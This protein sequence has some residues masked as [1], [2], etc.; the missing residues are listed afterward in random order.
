MSA[1]LA[2][3]DDVLRDAVRRHGGH[4]FSTAGDAFAAAFHT[5]TDALDAA[6]TAQRALQAT[7]WPGPVIRVRM[8]IHTGEAEERDGD[9]FGPVLNKVA[10]IM[11]A[12]NGGQILLSASAAELSSTWLSDDTSLIDL[13]AHR[14]HDVPGTEHLF[15]A[16]HVEL[17][18]IDLAIRTTQER[19]HNLPEY[20]TTFVGRESELATIA[21]LL[22]DHRLVT[23]SGV[24]GTGKTRLAV[25]TARRMTKGLSGGRWLVELAPVVDSDNIMLTIG[26][27]LELRPGPG[28]SIDEVVARHLA[29]LETLVIIDNCEHVLEGAID[30]ISTL[31]SAGPGVKVLAT[32]RESLGITGEAIVRVPSLGLP[33]DAGSLA[34]VESVHLFLDRAGEVR[35]GFEPTE[36]DLRAIA[37]ICVRIDGIPLGLEL[38][39]A[40]LRSLA[41]ADLA[42][43]L[44]E[45]FR[46]L[47]GSAKTALPR[48]RTLNATIDW[49]HDLLTPA[50]RAV[51]RRMA[52]FLNGFDLTAAEA[53][54]S[55]DSVDEADVLDRLDSLVD[56]SLLVT[57]HD[58]IVG[59]RYRMLEPV[60]QYAQEVLRGSGEAGDV[61]RAH[62]QH[63]ASFVAMAS[64]LMRRAG[65]M[66]W[67]RRLDEDYDNIRAAFSTLLEAGE[68]DG[69]LDM[70]FDL[71]C[72]W[73]HVGFHFEGITTIEE[74]LA[75]APTDTDPMRLVKA[76]FTMAA[77]GFETTLPR[78]VGD[79][80]HGLRLATATGDPNLIGRMELALGAAIRHST[81]RPD[82]AEHV[83][84][85]RDLI[86]Q[87]RHPYWWE[88][89]WED[90]FHD[91]LFSGYLPPGDGRRREHAKRAIETFEELGDEAQLIA[92]LCESAMGMLE[93]VDDW[94]TDNL[95]RACEMVERIDV[96]YWHGHAYYFLGE[97]DIIAGRTKAAVPRLRESLRHLEDCGDLS[98]WAGAMRALSLSHLR[99]GQSE[100]AK[101]TIAA[102]LRRT[103]PLP[104]PERAV[105]RALAIA[106]RLLLD[107]GQADR[108]A[109]IIGSA[110]AANGDAFLTS[111]L[112]RFETMAEEVQ[113][114]L[115]R[116]AS[117]KLG[118]GAS[119]DMADLLVSAAAWLE[120]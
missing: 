66:T 26:E 70:A 111:E 18:D 63:F 16:G 6:V 95:R 61:Q 22:D 56:K 11:S 54:C 43:R 92:A 79:A 8:G 84:R 78:S 50:E 4:V 69:Y 85:G 15:L 120:E 107:T 93:G 67:E 13:G 65:Q 101:A 52:M 21:D 42:D 81:S 48:Q 62:A 31:L 19:N 119:M 29:D 30:A 71:F 97:I 104:M 74:G 46:V 73:Q 20:L 116:D 64:P 94:I 24:G 83:L 112:P 45:S 9:Y 53:V 77:L 39:A 60:R 110:T 5:T 47:S 88:Q 51:F 98:C 113:D 57:A 37:R 59:T 25:E 28:A 80:E 2:V 58:P 17:P 105:P 41:P 3:H 36:A 55:C 115:G 10:R 33:S 40:R 108:A 1:S 90:A 38:A 49:S 76:S 100:D 14:L 75:V 72:Y 91:F 103:S 102:V 109:V 82:F 27:V 44:D 12:A 106:A 118:E 34:G 114:R 96:P 86:E 89:R 32:S 23:L 87:H 68:V 7:K 35:P 117:E 99:L